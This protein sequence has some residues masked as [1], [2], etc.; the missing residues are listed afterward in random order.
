MIT[1]TALACAL[2]HDKL[3]PIGRQGGV[4]TAATIGADAIAARLQQY[5]GFEVSTRAF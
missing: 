3:H 4:L 1:E 5:G 2:D